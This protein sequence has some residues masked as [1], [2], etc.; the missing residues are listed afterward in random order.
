MIGTRPFFIA[1]TR[2]LMLVEPSGEVPHADSSAPPPRL[3][4]RSPGQLAVRA[5]VRVRHDDDL[6]PL[7][8]QC[9]GERVDVVLDPAQPRV[10]EVAD[11]GDAQATPGSGRLRG[12]FVP[13]THDL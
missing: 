5:V 6:V 3:G 4:V 11:H 12:R 8:Q 9:L 7:S 2:H 13:K 1:L 10:E